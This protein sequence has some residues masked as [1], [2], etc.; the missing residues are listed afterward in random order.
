MLWDSFGDEIDFVLTHPNGYE[1]PQQTIMRE[2]AIRGGLVPDA[3]TAEKR[4]SLVTEGEAS[5][6]FCIQSGLAAEA[7]KVCFLPWPPGFLQV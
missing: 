3:A 7:M 6:H 2:A 1:G 4:V 5:L